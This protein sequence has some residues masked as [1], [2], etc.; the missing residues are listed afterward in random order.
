[1]IGRVLRAMAFGAVLGAAL[2]VGAVAQTK[3]NTLFGAADGPSQ[4]EPMPVG[5]YAKGCAAGLVEL[6]ETGPTWQAMRLSRNRNYGHPELVDYIAGLSLFARDRLGWAGLY[7]GDM[8]QPRGGP[9]TSGHSSHQIGLDADIWMLPPARLDLTRAEREEISSVAVRSADQLSVTR[10]WTPAH[11]ALLEAAA[12]DARVDRIFVAAAVKIE[13]CK[14]AKRSDKAWLQK[15]RP[16]YGHD[17]HFHVRLK[18]PRG[19]TLCE[20]QKPTVS[21]LSNGGNGCDDTLM[22]WVS[23]AYLNPEPPKEPAP[24]VR[25]PRDYTMADLPTQCTNVLSSR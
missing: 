21:E 25:G 22:Y 23:D 11:A 5:S 19:A 24:A 2:P 16:I 20:T 14:T 9:M 17:T 6:A 15:I 3:A 4:Q 13:M 10:A 8:S 12:S 1:M 18:C 7:V